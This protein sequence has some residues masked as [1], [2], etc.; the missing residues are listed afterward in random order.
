MKDPLFI[1]VC[2]YVAFVLFFLKKKISSFTSICNPWGYDRP[3]YLFSRTNS[4]LTYALFFF[5]FF[6]LLCLAALINCDL[7]V[8]SSITTLLNI[9]S[10]MIGLRLA[11]SFLPL[12]F[13]LSLSALAPSFS[14]P[15]LQL[16]SLKISVAALPRFLICYIVLT[17]ASQFLSA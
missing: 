2:R 16:S 6:H 4:S 7:W 13:H 9:Y 11:R 12:P 17:P 1:L 10:S 15:L 8:V 3:W 5:L 14:P